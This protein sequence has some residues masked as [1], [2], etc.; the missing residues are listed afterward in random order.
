MT[1]SVP[2]L[3]LGRLRLPAPLQSPKALGIIIIIDYIIIISSSNIRSSSSSS[4]SMY[5]GP[6]PEARP[7]G[8][9]WQVQSGRHDLTTTTTTFVLDYNLFVG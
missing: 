2:A 1:I 8:S 6:R 3:G 4:S 7:R 9:S 5:I